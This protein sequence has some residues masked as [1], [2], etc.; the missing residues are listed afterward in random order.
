MELFNGCN[1][2]VP[3]CRPM[4]PTWN[5]EGVHKCTNSVA[6][7]T[8]NKL[9]GV[10]CPSLSASPPTT[11][12]GRLDATRRSAVMIGHPL[13]LEPKS[14]LKRPQRLVVAGGVVCLCR[15][16]TTPS[17]YF[18]GPCWLQSG[19]R[20]VSIRTPILPIRIRRASMDDSMELV[21]D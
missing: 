16:I 19:F 6:I 15:W 2:G 7:I 18:H 10:V 21:H 9:R 8:S 12:E 17:V 4:V 3:I 20:R 13:A 11:C 14:R 1:S 5:S